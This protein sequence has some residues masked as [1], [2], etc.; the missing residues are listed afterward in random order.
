[1]DTGTVISGAGHGLLLAYLA[2]GNMFAPSFDAEPF[3]TTDVSIIS[4]EEFA[5]LSQSAAPAPALEP[6][7]E[8]EAVPDPE[9]EPEP[10]PEPTPAP[11]PEVAVE[12]EVEPVARPPTPEPEPP[13]SD[14]APLAEEAVPDQ[15]PRIA[16]IPVPD[17]SDAPEIADVPSPEIDQNADT[18]ITAEDVPAAAP[19]QATTE[20]VPDALDP[21]R[22]PVASLVPPVRP[23]PPL[24]DTTDDETEPE[25]A[26]A[27]DEVPATP[28]DTSGA[29][30]EALSGVVDTGPGL[31]SGP[32]MTF[33]EKDAFRVA[34][35]A[36]W[37]QGMLSSA[38]QRTTVLVGFQMNQDGTPDASSIRLL[39]AQGGDETAARTAF[40]AASRAIRRC[41]ARGFNLP[42]EKYSQW[43]E[44][45]IVFRADGPQIQ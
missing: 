20:V 19:D 24:P 42:P 11:E 14:E 32:P 43:R 16:D 40:E 41:G 1:M 31:G 3:S 33:G 36:C 29:L 34:V 25:V 27:S 17:V 39:D 38:A 45:E 21:A 23:T 22:A 35:A 28:I 8:P 13:V 9:P 18:D 4:S 2:F 26:E 30:E 44:V 37:N 7:P 12:P 10:E 5:A 15:S 6:E